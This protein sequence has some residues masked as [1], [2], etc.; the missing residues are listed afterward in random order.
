MLFGVHVAVAISAEIDV[1]GIVYLVCIFNGS[2]TTTCGTDVRFFLLR[3]NKI[4]VRSCFLRTR[5]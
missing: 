5:T 3:E 4:P 2:T 1:S